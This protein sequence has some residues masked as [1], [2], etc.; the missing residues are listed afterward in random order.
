MDYSGNPSSADT[1]NIIADFQPLAQP[2]AGPNYY[3]FS[4]AHFYEILIDNYGKGR[5]SVRFQFQFTNEYTP[6][7]L[8]VGGRSIEIPLKFAG[9]IQ[10]NSESN[11]FFQETYKV[12]VVTRRSAL[13]INKANGGTTFEK[14]FDNAGPKT[15]PDYASYAATKVYTVQW[16]SNLGNKCDEGKN[17]GKIFVGPAK[18]PFYIYLGGVFD[19]V[20]FN[21]VTIAQD[22][23]KNNQLKGSNANIIA[24]QIHKSCLLYS[25][26]PEASSIGVWVRTRAIDTGVQVAR[27]GMPLINEL[28]IGFSQKDQWNK[29]KPQNDAYYADFY[30]YP[31]LPKILDILFGGASSPI[32]PTLFPRDD[33]YQLLLLG[34]PGITDL[35]HQRKNS[36]PIPQDLLRLNTQTTGPFTPVPLAQQKP[37]G[38]LALDQNNVISGDLAGFPNG[39][40]PMDDI[41]DIYLRAAMGALYQYSSIFDPNGDGKNAAKLYSTQFT[42]GV[43]PNMNDYTNSF[44][45]L[46]SPLPGSYATA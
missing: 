9:Q 31:S 14:A 21:P 29:D 24:I 30:N 39:R 42:D 44:P 6:L 15:F 17:Q 34:V 4:D 11:L 37:L 46:A 10:A 40:R 3:Q 20:N 36:V 38:F 27:L 8:P 28:F 23:D 12:R 16:P 1:V 33:L 26:S 35:Y 18:D 41:V 7:N 32:E 45:W 2:Y 13:V 43:P 22:Y 19:L 5:T 25:D